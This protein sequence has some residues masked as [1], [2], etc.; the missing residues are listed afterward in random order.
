MPKTNKGLPGVGEKLTPVISVDEFIKDNELEEVMPV[1]DGVIEVIDDVTAPSPE[2]PS[3]SVPINKAKIADVGNKIYPVSNTTNDY[4]TILGYGNNG[5]GKTTFGATAKNA[6]FINTEFG[7][8]SVRNAKA[9]AYDIETWDD[10]EALYWFLANQPGGKHPNIDTLVWDTLTRLLRI[11]LRHAVLGAAASDPS[12][13]VIHASQRDWGTA[14]DRF[15]F[16][17]AAFKKLPYHQ[18]WLCQER[19]TSDDADVAGYQGFP[20]LSRAV[21]SYIQGDADVIGR[22]EKRVNLETGDIEFVFNVAPSDVYVT[23]DRL[24]VLGNGMINPNFET[25]LKLFKEAK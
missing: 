10:V 1:E 25:I 19:T 18:I 16:W 22:F 21:R 4:L 5:T 13:D 20:D 11:A 23:R 2:S 17:I 15:I 3:V 7:L 8:K 9:L 12:K 14:T 6:L 24:N